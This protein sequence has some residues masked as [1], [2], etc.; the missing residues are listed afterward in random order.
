MTPYIQNE[1]VTYFWPLRTFSLLL[2]LTSWDEQSLHAHSKTVKIS[3]IRPQMANIEA[4]E[5]LSHQGTQLMGT[6]CHIWAKMGHNLAGNWSK[7]VKYCPK[8]DISSSIQTK[9]GHN[10]VSYGLYTYVS[11]T[12]HQN[13]AYQALHGHDICIFIIK[14]C[15]IWTKS[16]HWFTRG[17]AL[18][19]FSHKKTFW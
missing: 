3:K 10:M 17:C 7:S 6:R 13:K 4:L 9:Y 8:S 12:Y 1:K 15:Q 18:C 11:I 16:R 19:L 2:D 14:I 5:H